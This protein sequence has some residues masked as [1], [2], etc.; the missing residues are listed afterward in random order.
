MIIWVGERFK[1]LLARRAMDLGNN[2]DDHL[3]LWDCGTVGLWDSCGLLNDPSLVRQACVRGKRDDHLGR[4]M[5]TWVSK[6]KTSLARQACVRGKR[7]DHLG[8]WDCGTVG[9]WDCGTVGLL[10]AFE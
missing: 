9:L 1:P 10:R 5:I 8:L 7:D 4:L 6:F 3:G 2:R